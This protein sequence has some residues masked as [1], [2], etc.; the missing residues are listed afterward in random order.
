MHLDEVGVPQEMAARVYKPFVV[1]RLQSMGKTPIEARKAIEE[2]DPLAVKALEI[3]MEHRPVLMNRAPSLHKFSI[4]A[5]KPRLIQGKAVEVNPLIVGGFNMDFDGDTAGIHVPVSE[6]A[7]KEAFDRLLPSKNLFSPQDHSLVHSP[8]KETALGVY[9]MT[10]P[11]V[12]GNTPSVSNWESLFQLYRDKKVKANQAARVGGQVH[13]IGQWIYAQTFP[14]AVRPAYRSTTRKLM[15]ADLERAGRE[16]SSG[17]A[18]RVITEVKNLGNHYVTEVGFSVSLRDLEIDTK[19]RDAVIRKAKRRSKTVGY[20]VAANEAVAELSLLLDAA[21]NNRFVEAGPLSGALGKKGQIQQMVLSPVGTRDHK[22]Q[23]V[24]IIVGKSYAEGHDLGAY[25]STTP[26]ARKGLIDKGL[27]VADTGYLSRLLVNSNVEMTIK[28]DDCGTMQGIEMSLDDKEISDRYGAEGA[29]RNQII[30]QELA[31]RLRQ[32]GE[33]RIKVRSPMT[34]KA[35]GGIC[36]K[37]F[38]LDESGKSPRIGFHIGALA[39]QT[40]G[41]RATQVTLRAFHTGGAVGSESNLGFD[42]IKQ[43]LEMPQ[44]IRGKAVLAQND[45]VVNKIEPGP[46]GGDYVFVSGTRHFIPQ[47]LATK[48]T[49]GQRVKAGDQLSRHGIV[50]PKELLDLTGDLPRVQN[51]LIDE[52]D[53]NYSASGSKIRRKIYETA[54]TPLT[55]RAKVTEANDGSKFGVVS[56]DFVLTNQI[57]EYNAKIRKMRGKEI[58]YEP[59]VAGIKAAPSYSTDFVGSLIHEKL[60]KTLE[61]APTMGL[62]T[63]LQKGHPISQLALTNLRSIDSVKRPVKI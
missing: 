43:I 19:K 11:K 56:G 13:C 44:T 63:D 29:Y 55:N 35:V 36:Q 14:Q 38:G 54:I 58:E 25:L 12:R 23:V 4:Q 39:G 59:L 27:S 28:A 16:L 7:R 30:T 53:K 34:C 52:L 15:D 57:E 26:G 48:V 9:L 45:G 17:E 1:K 33:K 41:E 3:E 62:K 21:I 5:F 24:P 60:Q 10:T 49:R 40:I 47:E 8:T 22:N 46:T 42:R 61:R 6:E 18:A 51:Y 32:K 2:N 37:C 31:R 50:E 20:D